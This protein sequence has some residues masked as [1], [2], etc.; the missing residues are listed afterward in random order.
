MNRFQI[1]HR[2]TVPCTTFSKDCLTDKT[3]KRDLRDSNL[4]WISKKASYCDVI[5]GTM[6]SQMTRVT[7][8]YS[9]VYSGTD[10]RKYQSFASLAFVR[11][12]H[13]WPGNSPHKGPVTGKMFPCHHVT[14]NLLYIWIREIWGRKVGCIPIGQQLGEI[15]NI[16]IFCKTSVETKK[17]IWNDEVGQ[18]TFSEKTNKKQMRGYHRSDSRFALSHERRCYCVTT[19]VIGWAQA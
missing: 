17:C 9:T 8:V 10:H 5:M 11:G 7:I 12:I 3:D 19:S 1:S 2:S 16:N 6:A 14:S 18:V 13:R 4:R 15:W